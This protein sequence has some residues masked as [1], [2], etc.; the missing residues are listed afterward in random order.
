[1]KNIQ[2]EMHL[3]CYS[4]HLHY[5]LYCF[6]VLYEKHFVYLQQERAEIKEVDSCFYVSNRSEE[7]MK[8]I[9]L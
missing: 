9:K 6:V 3:I 7:G 2:Y 1:M 8:V 5:S 4:T